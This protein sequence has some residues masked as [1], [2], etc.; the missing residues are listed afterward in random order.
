MDLPHLHQY[1]TEIMGPR[2]PFLGI[3]IQT[4]IAAK[5]DSVLPNSHPPWS[6]LGNGVRHMVFLAAIRVWG[7]RHLASR[8][9][10]HIF[11]RIVGPVRH[12]WGPPFSP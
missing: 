11:V 6:R 3:S 2:P 10:G 9:I 7:M 12:F 4:L 1:L 8:W 5:D